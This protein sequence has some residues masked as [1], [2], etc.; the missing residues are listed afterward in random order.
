MIG[1]RQTGNDSVGVLSEAETSGRPRQVMI[2]N[3]AAALWLAFFVGVGCWTLN[4]VAKRAQR[5]QCLA[6]GGQCEMYIYSANL[7]H[8]QREG[9]KQRG[10]IAEYL[11]DRRPW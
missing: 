10:W 11:K 9:L 2:E 5:E 4:S 3:A 6:R 8:R 7:S 1:L